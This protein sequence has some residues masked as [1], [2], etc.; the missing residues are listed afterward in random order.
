MKSYC[1]MAIAPVSQDE[2]ISRDGCC[3]GGT[4]SR[5]YQIPPDPYT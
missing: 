3:D 2:K 4:T 1:L 5:I